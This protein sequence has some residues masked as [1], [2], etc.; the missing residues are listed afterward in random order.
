MKRCVPG[1]LS[2]FVC[3]A[4]APDARAEAIPF[5]AVL[6]AGQEVTPPLF[7]LADGIT[8]RPISYGD[9]TLLLN[10]TWTAFTFSVTVYNIDLT[11][12]QTADP[13]DNLVAAHIHAP[14]PPGVNAG[15]RFG[16][17]GAPFND[18][19]PNDVVVTPFAEGVGGTITSKWDAV[20]GNNTTLAAQIPNLLAGL[21]YINFH[22]VQNPAGEVR[23]QII[24][25]P[26][27]LALVGLGLVGLAGYGRTRMRRAA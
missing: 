15:V 16:F 27:S 8:E 1:L 2:A 5:T 4:V 19:N 24:P 26:G 6:T 7:T 17:F 14:A 20:E 23:G 18:N 12:S 25:E 10:E 11:G 21:A 13:N 3:L 22:T 9:A